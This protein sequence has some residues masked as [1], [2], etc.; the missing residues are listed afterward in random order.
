[1]NPLQAYK[2]IVDYFNLNP[3]P[4]GKRRLMQILEDVAVIREVDVCVIKEV[5]VEKIIPKKVVTYK[6]VKRRL[7]YVEELQRICLLYK[8]TVEDVFSKT[9]KHEVVR[10]R[11]H[12]CRFIKLNC[13]KVTAV[14]LAEFLSQS[15]HTTVLHYWHGDIKG[16]KIEKLIKPGTAN[17]Q[18]R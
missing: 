7:D 8:T 12:F 2:D 9:K 13:P 14:S 5:P 11:A 15:D 16:C 3:S 18:P 6:F 4:A 1:M 10:A 17:R